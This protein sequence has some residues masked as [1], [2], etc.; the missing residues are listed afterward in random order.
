VKDMTGFSLWWLPFLTACGLLLLLWIAQIVSK[1]SA[2]HLI[3]TYRKS[4]LN[5]VRRLELI[6]VAL[7]RMGNVSTSIGSDGYWLYYE[8]LLEHFHKLLS[9]VRQVPPFGTRVD[10]L[11]SA[12]ELANEMDQ[13][14]LTM[15]KSGFGVRTLERPSPL[16]IGCYFC[17]RPFTYSGL[18]KVRAKV[19]G[20]KLVVSS[21]RM[22]K[23][24]LERSQRVKVLYFMKNGSPKHWSDVSEYNPVTDFATLNTSALQKRRLEIVKDD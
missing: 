12:H 23:A 10:I 20:R 6:T 14:L 19:E 1:E 5:L 17:S 8:S 2:N 24:E 18:V 16:P 4:Y 15:Q 13:R 7:N 9:L 3:R 22:C 11:L 21:C